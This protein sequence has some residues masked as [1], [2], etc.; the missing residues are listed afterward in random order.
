MRRVPEVE[1]RR[2][3]QDRSKTYPEPA[4]PDLQVAVFQAPADIVFVETVDPLEVVTPKGDI[5]P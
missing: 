3:A 1:Y 5:M 4:E 2:S